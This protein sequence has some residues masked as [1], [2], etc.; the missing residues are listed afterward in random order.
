MWNLYTHGGGGGRLPR[1]WS[2]AFEAAY[3]DLI[4]DVPAVRDAA[5]LEIARMSLRSLQVDPIPTKSKVSHCF[6]LK[7]PR[8]K[9][10]LNWF[11][12]TWVS[13]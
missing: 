12:R 9:M 5:L 1:F 11:L 4:G 7:S 8:L 3:E 13:Q 2:E 6:T 10:F